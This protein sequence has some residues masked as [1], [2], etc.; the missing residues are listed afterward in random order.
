[1]TSADLMLGYQVAI[2]PWI[3]KV[4]AGASEES[5][6]VVAHG[7]GGLPY[8]NRNAVQGSRIGFKGALETW[9]NIDNIAFLQTDLSWSEPFQAYGARIRGGYRLTPALST[10]FELSGHGNANHDAE[11]LGGFLRFEWTAGEISASG[12]LAAKGEDVT[13]LYGSLAVML[14][15]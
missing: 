15:F 8:D 5:H 2:G 11:R 1:M 4:F 6:V 9:W 3:V 13:G 12:G 7:T 10:G 14:R